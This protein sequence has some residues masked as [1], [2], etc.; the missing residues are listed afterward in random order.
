MMTTHI[1]EKRKAL[2]EKREKL[3]GRFSNPKPE[4]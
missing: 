4:S 3:I 1:D 2:V